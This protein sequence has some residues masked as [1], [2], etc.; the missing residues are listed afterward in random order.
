MDEHE[1]ADEPHRDVIPPHRPDE[2]QERL[3]SPPPFRIQH[4]SR[5]DDEGGQPHGVAAEVEV[6]YG[7]VEHKR[8]DIVPHDET[9]NEEDI[10]QH[11]KKEVEEEEYGR[12]DLHRLR[13]IGVEEVVKEHG[14]S[15]CAYTEMRSA[16]THYRHR[17]A[18]DMFRSRPNQLSSL[19]A[20]LPIVTTN[21]PGEKWL[22]PCSSTVSEVTQYHSSS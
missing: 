21:H 15:S 9:R 6:V 10:E 18:E 5:D 8:E 7:M 1:A 20:H 19:I 16:S 14:Y 17:C 22:C 4:G 2:P 3:A 11:E 13:V 12:E